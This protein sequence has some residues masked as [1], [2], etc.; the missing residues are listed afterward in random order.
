MWQPTCY[1]CSFPKGPPLVSWPFREI[2][3]KECDVFC[4]TKRKVKLLKIKASVYPK[5]KLLASSVLERTEGLLTPQVKHSWG[6]WALCC[7]AGGTKKSKCNLYSLNILYA[8]ELP[9]GVIIGATVLS[10][11]PHICIRKF[12]SACLYYFQTRIFLGIQ[13]DI[14]H[15]QIQFLTNS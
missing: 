11:S 15:A 4:L 14:F 7:C 10:M 13:L 12:C 9:T 8:K 6:W 1:S 2:L 3:E 5:Y